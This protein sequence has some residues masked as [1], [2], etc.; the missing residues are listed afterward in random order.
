MHLQIEIN[1]E[2]D[3]IDNGVKDNGTDCPIALSARAQYPE[4]N[5]I[6]VC[7]YSIFM[8]GECFDLPDEAVSF[9]ENFDAGKTVSP[10]EFTTL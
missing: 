9:I 6:E 7:E 1:I 10:F 3:A 8:F 5:D 4:A 2:Q